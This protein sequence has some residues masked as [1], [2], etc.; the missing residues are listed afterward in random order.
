MT[1]NESPH[2]IAFSF[3]LAATVICAGF[4]VLHFMEGRAWAVVLQSVLVAVNLP[5]VFYFAVRMLRG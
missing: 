4:G 3:S 1:K 2:F 5:F